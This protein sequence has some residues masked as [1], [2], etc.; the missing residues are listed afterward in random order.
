[1]K[2]FS[3]LTLLLAITIAALVV[4]TIRLNRELE[5]SRRDRWEERGKI[6]L[7]HVQLMDRVLVN[8]EGQRLGL[9]LDNPKEW[10]APVREMLN[11]DIKLLSLIK[12]VALRPLDSNNSNEYDILCNP[13]DD[14]PRAYEVFTLT[15]SG[16]KCIDIRRRALCP[17]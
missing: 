3:L 5:K 14:D 6:E 13:V 8:Q 16:D 11:K 17:W 9:L 1:M 10:L 12:E 2:S 7:L 4:N 15:I